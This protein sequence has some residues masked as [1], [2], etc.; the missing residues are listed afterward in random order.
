MEIGHITP[1]L[2]KTITEK[3]YMVGTRYISAL[4]HQNHANYGATRNRDGIVHTS[5]R[6]AKDQSATNF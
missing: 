6:Y 4:R 5:H 3:T 1:I 2:W